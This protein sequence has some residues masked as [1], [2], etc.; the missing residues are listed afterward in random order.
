MP[1]SP[2]IL[3]TLDQARIWRAEART[4]GEKVVMVPT[5]GA[6]HDGHLELVRTARAEGGRV[7]VSIFVNPTQF[8]PNEDFDAY[9]R[10]LAEDVQKLQGDG[11]CDAVFAPAPTEMYPFGTNRTWVSVDRL[12]D[13]LC[14]AAR[15]G[16]FKGVTTV[17][18]RLF[19]ILTPDVAVFGLKDAQQFFILKRMSQE[20]GFATRLVGVPTVREVD[21]LAMSS[22][23]R[24]LN[25]SERAAAPV[26]YQ[27]LQAAQRS[28]LKN[29]ERDGHQIIAQIEGL[30]AAEPTC[31]RDYVSVVDT[32]E[33]QPLVSL[34]SGST[35]LIALAAYFGPARL[36]DNVIVDVP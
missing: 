17:V 10:T 28:I 21:G 36:I 30:L 31:R 4:R 9:P 7:I 15:P 22:R 12:G 25:P 14:G 8:G 16:H 34:E 13:H 3:T 35:V 1:A 2:K 24:Y 19:T 5:M 32:Q 33:M 29:G 23:N 20:M 27:S 11:C 26:L 6:L 18:A